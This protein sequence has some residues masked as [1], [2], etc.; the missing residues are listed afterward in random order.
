MF[1]KIKKNYEASTVNDDSL[2]SKRFVVER[3]PDYVEFY[4]LEPAVVLDIIMDDTH[5][6]FS[7][8]LVK[9]D[10]WPVN[11]DGSPATDTTSDYTWVGRIK[12]RFLHSQI[13]RDKETLFWAKPLEN[14]GVTE[15]PLMNEVV[16]VVRYL[17]GFY[18]SRKLNI[19]GNVNANG[20]FSVERRAGL[21]DQNTDEY[22]GKPYDGPISVM[23]AKGDP[24]FSGVYGKYFKFNHHVRAIKRYEGDTIIESRFGSTIRFGAY[25]GNRANDMGLG[26]Y[27]DG[28][29]NPHILIRNR[30]A[31]VNPSNKSSFPNKSF[32]EESINSDGSSIHLTSGKTL[33]DFVT[34]CK[35]T[36]F[37]NGKNE[38]Q[39]AYSP[40]G[41][42]SF[43]PPP[44]KGDQIIINSDR[45]V[46]SSKAG[47]SM[48][49]SKKRLGMVSDGEFVVDAHDQIVLTTNKKVTINSPKIYLGEY[50]KEG[51]PVLLGQ[52]QVDWMKTLCDKIQSMDDQIIALSNWC[53]THQHI[54]VKSGGDISGVP[55]NVAS[56]TE[57]SNAIGTLKTETQT[58]QGTPLE[59]TK[60]DRV[61]TVGNTSVHGST[62][63][64][65]GSI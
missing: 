14:T 29:G 16:S 20:D 38:E 10:E 9:K 13:G 25:D 60:S 49:F 30:Q 62:G 40:S 26:E 28:G 46:F 42:T 33:S 34:T 3:K 31:A 18:Y 37:Q 52:M 64:D 35:K 65:G 41:A 59:N 44:L 39:P 54:G 61:F 8:K 4:E 12:F 63:H 17:D 47:E 56:P 1:E 32:V 51:E 36:M 11:I 19:E 6:I 22:T 27:S 24:S 2:A 48:F 58:H 43:T 23:N 5:P 15:F 45:L 57:V 7:E 55:R 53:K 50:G 21:V